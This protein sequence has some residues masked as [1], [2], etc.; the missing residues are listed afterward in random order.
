MAIKKTYRVEW[1]HSWDRAKNPIPFM[2]QAYADGWERIFGAKA[3][4]E[5]GFE[6]CDECGGCLGC[7][8]CN[9]E[10]E[11]DHG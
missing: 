1:K 10:P 7:G 11:P 5:P 6:T 9:C 2:G 8:E 3:E 4:P